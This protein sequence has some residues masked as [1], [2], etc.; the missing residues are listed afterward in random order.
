MDLK[1]N[2][3]CGSAAVMLAF[4]G[5]ALAGCTSG[6]GDSA[7][8]AIYVPG[9]YEGQG[10]GM[11]VIT[12]EVTVDETH[13]TDVVLEGPGETQG[14]GGKEAIEDGTFVDQILETQSSDV[15]TVSGATLSSEG[16]EEAVQSALDQALIG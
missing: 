12:A 8:E 4:G 14:V 9:T 11:G 13:I 2:L 15:D 7:E 3:V 6:E 1:R 16:V 5:T 10:Q